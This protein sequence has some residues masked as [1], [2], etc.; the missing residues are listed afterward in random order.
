M[1]RS[2]ALPASLTWKH[3]VAT[4]DITKSWDGTN[5]PPALDLGSGTSKVAADQKGAEPSAQSNPNPDPD[6]MVSAAADGMNM[7]EI[8]LSGDAITSSYETG[9]ATSYNKFIAVNGSPTMMPTPRNARKTKMERI[10][11]RQYW[12]RC[13]RDRN[14]C[15]PAHIDTKQNLS[16]VFIKILY[17]ATFEGQVLK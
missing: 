4:V 12:V 3:E 16:D 13:L 9:K 6:W 5:V 8:A 11:C 10:N 2:A 15:I 1:D 7:T 17:T 14:I